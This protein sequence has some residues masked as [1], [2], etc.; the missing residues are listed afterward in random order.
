MNTSAL[1]DHLRNLIEA[2][3]AETVSIAAHRVSGSAGVMIDPDRSYHPAS[4]FKLCVM[5]EVHRQVRLGRLRLDDPVRVTNEFRSIADGSH[6]SLRAEDDSEKA[7]YEVIGSYLPRLELVWRM[8]SASSNLAT[9]ILM[10]D[11]DAG[12]ITGFMR[13]LGADGII[14][15][16]GVE[17]YRAYRL[18]LNNAANARALAQVLLR[19][20]RGEVVTAED[21]D[22]MISALSTQQFNQ[23]I[24]A[25][26]PVGVRVAHKTGWTADFHHDAGIVYPP[27][28]EPFVVC[29]LTKG[30]DESRDAEAHELVAVLAR[31]IYDHWQ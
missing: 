10:E 18:G 21:S 22:E 30:F 11:L 3:D 27:T 12:E 20:A 17:D 4:I 24:P 15:R 26:L 19:L 1:S 7:L 5:I 16:R 14:V 13:E 29:I 28:G 25:K 9:N 23:M 6:Y 2:S 8:I 31:T